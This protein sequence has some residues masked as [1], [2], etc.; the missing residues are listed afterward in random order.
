M[1]VTRKRLQV[2]GEAFRS[3][4]HH[5]FP[6]LHRHARQAYL[7]KDC[8]SFE[9]RVTKT[10]SKKKKRKNV[11]AEILLAP[12]KFLINRQPCQRWQAGK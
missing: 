6:L 1:F 5:Y 10:I 12:N 11:L 9:S 2:K 4:I 3:V 8:T 7:L